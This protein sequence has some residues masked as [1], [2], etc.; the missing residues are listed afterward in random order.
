MTAYEQGSGDVPYV[1]PPANLFVLK[2]KQDIMKKREEN[3]DID[4]EAEKELY[5]FQDHGTTWMSGDSSAANEMGGWQTSCSIMLLD[6][7]VDTA[8]DEQILVDSG[9]F[10]HACPP[11]FAPEIPIVPP[12]MELRVSTAGNAESLQ[13]LGTKTVKMLIGNHI[14]QCVFQEIDIRR[15]PFSVASLMRHGFKT[16]FEGKNMS[17]LG[18]G[19][20]CR[21]PLRMQGGH[22]FSS[23]KVLAT[24]NGGRRVE[25]LEQA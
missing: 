6:V 20:W 3:R 22:F 25:T 16:V 18:R 11:T 8:D 7:S 5:A 9:A 1:V 17:Y 14:V 12:A 10:D 4:L 21:M 19:R 13:L 24:Q 2:G 23:V 15:V